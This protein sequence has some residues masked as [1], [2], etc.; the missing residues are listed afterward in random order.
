LAFT[1]LIDDAKAKA[2]GVEV[3]L[4]DHSAKCRV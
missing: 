1:S 4:Y 3:G 2:L